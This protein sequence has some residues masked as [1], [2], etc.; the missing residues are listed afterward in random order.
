MSYK[1]FLVEDEI[2]TREG[3]RDKVGWQAHGFEFC[4]E[5][6]DGEIALPLLQRLKIDIDVTRTL[7][8][9]SVAIQ[10][11]AAI[12]RALEVSSAKIL[13][14]DEPT[15]PLDAKETAQL[16]DV[17]RRLQSEGVGI[18][19][20]T[21]FMDQ[22]YEVADRITVLRNGKLVGTY[23][24]A[25]LPRLELIRKMIGRSLTEFD[26]MSKIKLE[27]AKNIQGPL[28]LE[29]EGLGRTGSLEPI[30]LK[31]H[32]GEVVGLAGLLLT[33]AGVALVAIVGTGLL[34][35]RSRDASLSTARRASTPAA[36]GCQLKPYRQDQAASLIEDG[37]IL[38]YERNGGPTCLDELYAIYPDGRIVGEDGTN[39]IEKQLTAADL[40]AL[41]TA[42]SDRGWFTENMYDTWHTP[43]GQCFGYY[44][45][46]VHNGQQKTV[47]AV[48]GGTDAPA[49]YWQ[50][51]SI[52][53]GAI[54]HFVAE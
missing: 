26:D 21:H 28:V 38:T 32:A 50:V 30:D 45:T 48:D 9:Y 39:R 16:F 37:A 14:L 34:L 24:T 53:N 1:V 33:G 10:Q 52:L 12:V 42:I 3:I 11:M 22:V 17:M 35:N 8:D 23:D 19:F 43:C 29:A 41:M 18:V 5:A 13:I 46:V 40:A 49:D 27:S 20:I 31:L 4:G 36:A 44:L 54:P 47:K 2:V 6:P 7:G 25:S 51:V 15:S